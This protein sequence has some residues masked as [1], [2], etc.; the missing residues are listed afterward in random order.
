MH[1][2]ELQEDQL[3]IQ[4]TLA[5]ARAIE[6]KDRRWREERRLRLEAQSA[7]PS[8]GIEAPP[9]GGEHEV[10][11][12]S[13][14]RVAAQD[15]VVPPSATG[16][17]AAPP[18]A[19]APA[20]APSAPATSLDHAI[21]AR[22][23]RRAARAQTEAGISA[24]NRDDEEWARARARIERSPLSDFDIVVEDGAPRAAAAPAPAPAP[25]PPRQ[26]EP[27]A[28]APTLRRDFGKATGPDETWTPHAFGGKP[29]ARR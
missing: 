27:E 7:G 9:P 3:R 6:E 19:A 28:P 12:A 17:A 21:A 18:P 15:G 20:P 1:P 25:A 29:K 13:R 26:A 23:E 4:R 24:D 2:Q 14:A 22:A 16:S 8:A 5:G 11:A 10:W